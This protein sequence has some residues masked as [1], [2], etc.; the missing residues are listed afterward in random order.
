MDDTTRPGLAPTAA[1][2]LIGAPLLM[3]VG[4]L[5]LVPF[6]DQGWNDVLTKAAAHQNTSDAGWLIAMAASGLLAAAALSMAR[7][8]HSAGRAKAAAFATVTTALGWAGSAGICAG[9]L[10][11][12]YQGKASDRA[13]QVKLMQDFNAGHSGFV[14]LMCA[15][16]AVGYVV[17]SVGLA[18]SGLVGKGVAILIAVGGVGTLLTMPGPL[19][20][21]LVFAALV[22]LAGQVLL[23]RA[24]GTETVATAPKPTWEPVSS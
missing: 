24:V 5:L 7:L 8:L 17:L 13:V 12:S 1:A 20:A 9:G 21:L 4:R 14:F 10:M 16:A 2:L 6:D 19:K 18:R 3:A 15:F 22:L 11:L 23:V